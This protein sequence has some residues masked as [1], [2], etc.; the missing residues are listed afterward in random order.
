MYQLVFQGECVAGTD[1]A[2]ARENAR[3]LFRASVEQIERMF[4][5]R[6][7]V[8][9]N[10][11]EREQAD[12]YREVLHRHGMIA[13]VEAM[14]ETAP[15]TPPQSPGRSPVP[16]RPASAQ[17]SQPA[18]AA[19]ASGPAAASTGAPGTEPGERLSLAGARADAILSESALQLDPAGVDL[20]PRR[21]TEAPEFSHLEEWS[22][23][24]PGTELG[25]SRQTP[26]PMV[27]DIS[28]LS[29]VE[30]DGEGH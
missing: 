28:H 4:S 29:L 23:A 11:L 1:Q 13:R 7:V 19:A 25:V 3:T 2:T 22:L 30:G 27:P 10:R 12:K 20:A 16:P 17:T 24:P 18:S 9:R 14:A 5:G 15:A 8:I 6:P 26:P 21:V